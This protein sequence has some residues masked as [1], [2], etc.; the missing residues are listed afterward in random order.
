MSY[1]ELRPPIF[2]RDK[3][4]LVSYSGDPDLPVIWILLEGKA[5]PAHKKQGIDVYKKQGIESNNN[6]MSLINNFILHNKSS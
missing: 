2:P 1:N 4:H 3:Q 5:F 6:Y